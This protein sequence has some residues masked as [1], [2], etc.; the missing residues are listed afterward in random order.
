MA[1][2]AF[3]FKQTNNKN[4]ILNRKITLLVLCGFF[5]FLADDAVDIS[6][7]TA[8]PDTAAST[9][10]V[11]ASGTAASSD[12]AAASGTAASVDSATASG[13]DA[14]ASEG[15][16]A[17]KTSVVSGTTDSIST[18]D[19]SIIPAVLLRPARGEVMIY[20]I[21]AVIGEMGQ[22][23]SDTVSYN[24]A[25]SVL[26]DVQRKVN[27]SA[28]LS[29]LTEDAKARLFGKIDEVVPRKFRLG[30]GKIE[31]DGTTSFL[32]RFIGRESELA[33]EL[34]LI[35]EDG[36]W[37]TDDILS[38]DVKPLSNGESINAYVFTPYERFY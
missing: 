14:T 36:K 38:E 24:F 22:G 19:T 27:N 35:L 11:A 32:F 2:K 13:T 26:G 18:I 9:D 21:D 25:R 12:S 4:R 30:G 29:L 8:I 33:G 15:T 5:V 3:R 17:I 28:R 23:E 1:K 37:I 20:P 31:T 10:S 7:T 34:Y 16:P 6:D